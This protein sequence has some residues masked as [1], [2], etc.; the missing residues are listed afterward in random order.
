M[1]ITAIIK[2]SA[3]SK[4]FPSRYR[5][6]LQGEGILEIII[7]RLRLS[8]RI[9]EI[10]L[11]TSNDSA[12]DVLVESAQKQG[13]ACYRN[14]Y[15]DLFERLKGAAQQ[16]KADIFVRISG[17]YPLIDP[18]EIDSLLD[19]FVPSG[20]LFGTNEHMRGVITGL[21]CEVFRKELF[22][23]ISVETVS[24]AQKRFGA[25]CFQDFLDSSEMFFYDNEL[26]RP[27]YRLTMAVPE[28]AEIISRILSL[29]LP[30]N[31]QIVDFLDNN[32]FVVKYAE[33]NLATA[34]ETG[35]EKLLLYPEKIN[36][37]MRALDNLDNIDNSYPVSV[38]LSLTNRCNLECAWCSDKDIRERTAGDIDFEVLKKTLSDFAENGTTG[39]VIEGGGEPTLYDKFRETAEFAKKL[40]LKLGL[41]SNGCEIPYLEYM[42]SFDWI[43]ISL[44]A[45]TPDQFL[46]GKGYDRFEKIINNIQQLCDNKKT[47]T[48]GIGYVLSKYNEDRLEEL[49]LKFQHMDLNYIQIRPVIDSPDIMP[50]NTNIEYLTKHSTSGF[51]VNVAH[52]K[53]HALTGNSNLPCV[54]HSLSSVIAANGDVFIC[55]RL[56]KYDWLEPIGNLNNETFKAI[57]LGEKRKEQ[58]RN[59]LDSKFCR[60]WCP[61]CRL[62]KYNIILNNAS[63]IKT[64]GFI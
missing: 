20:K 50:L 22:D 15:A 29:E 13:I 55:G 33:Q 60:K 4:H 61:E 5:E 12:D 18:Y 39:V 43:R 51:K 52:M 41:I 31:P 2:A 35:L 7:K 8:K 24:R 32:P 34:H 25:K 30:F 47:A 49:I 19:S 14:N 9:N 1:K 17:N 26:S 63:A 64:K 56:N 10:I 21:G 11:A 38:E 16:A 6:K 46:Q 54:A 36:N 59:L 45:A 27:A 42:N 58:A 37:A 44:D 23:K 48:L 62:T 57:W 28:D 3:I 40:G 53:D